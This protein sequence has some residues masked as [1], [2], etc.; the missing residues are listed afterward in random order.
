MSE[1]SIHT[2]PTATRFGHRRPAPL[3]CGL[4]VAVA[5]AGLPRAAHA[6][7]PVEV[8]AAEVEL[9]ERGGLPAA[10]DAAL[11]RVLIKASGSP[12]LGTASA[13]RSITRDSG[14]LVSRYSTLAD[15]QVRV[16]FDR[17]ALQAALDAAGQPVWGAER[18]LVALWYAVDAG[19]G[20]RELLGEVA[21][22]AGAGDEPVDAL[23][24]QLLDAAEARGLPVVL[25]LLDGEDRRRIS[26][27]DVWGEFAEPLR[28]ASARYEADALLV[29][30]A[31]SFDPDARR[32]RW[33]LFV[34]R[35]VV[36]WEGTPA[37][38]PA[39]AA[40]YFA[41][42]LATFAGAAGQVR[43]E[44]GNIDTLAKY[45]RLRRY[46][47]G[48]SVVAGA[49]IVRVDDDRIEFELTVRGD[50]NR[51]R[52][53]LDSGGPLTAALAAAPVSTALVRPADL[54]YVW[55]EPR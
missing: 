26:F 37:A 10:F 23:R 1:F 47:L 20:N 25:P 28:V 34:G 19:A 13:R 29:G 42:R 11:E 46:L 27:A 18:P 8:F 45:G 38:G 53:A 39:Q 52:E 14:A 5:V 9:P 6:E 12:A 3:L 40:D 36:A 50:A 41:Q 2:Q 15:N 33:R 32:V 4:L 31:R 44:V 51:L 30:R 16:E 7:V 49:S 54:R 22:T 48:L 17:E 35:E 43:L 55:G 21:E 24:Q